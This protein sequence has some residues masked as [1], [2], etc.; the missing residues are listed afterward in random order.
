[1][2]ATEVHM[3]LTESGENDLCP[4]CEHPWY[5]HGNEHCTQALCGCNEGKMA[6]WALPP[7]QF[8]LI[9]G[10]PVDG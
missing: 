10:E 4:E 1:M 2:S 3:V 8:E 7:A 5:L 6:V 9:T